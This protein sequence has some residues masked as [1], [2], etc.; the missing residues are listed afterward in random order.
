MLTFLM[1]ASLKLPLEQYKILTWEL[2]EI[3]V[4][5]FQYSKNFDI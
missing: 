2:S 4:S 3:K 1:K 5:D